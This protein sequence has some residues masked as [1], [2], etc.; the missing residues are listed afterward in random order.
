MKNN[1]ELLA[2]GAVQMFF[3]ALDGELDIQGIDIEV[4]STETATILKATTPEYGKHYSTMILHTECNRKFMKE[5]HTFCELIDEK[6][7]EIRQ[8]ETEMDERRF[9]DYIDGQISELKISRMSWRSFFKTQ[10]KTQT[11]GFCWHSF[12]FQS[13]A[14]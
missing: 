5:I 7:T 13:F 10:Q 12:Y 11:R 8:S 1:R 14:Y 9:E 4:S 3:W 6:Q 2:A